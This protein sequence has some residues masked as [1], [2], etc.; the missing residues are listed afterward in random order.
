MTL[1]TYLFFDG[2]CGEAFDFYKSVFGGDFI[3]NASF[4]EGPPELGAA[5]DEK[6][7]VM[8]VSFPI[9][10]GVLMGSD[11]SRNHGPAPTPGDNFAISVAPE[12]RE[13]CDEYL[14][15]LSEDGEVIMPMED[16]FWGAYFGMCRDKF[17][18]K[19]MINF[20]TAQS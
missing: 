14:A 4:G 18:I 11:V 8:H 9:G 16:A 7:R 6:D 5:E 1:Y 12:S 19:W 10:S 15:K 13:Q 3:S 20:E 2:N 17:G